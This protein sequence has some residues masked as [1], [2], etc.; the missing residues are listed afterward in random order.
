[1]YLSSHIALTCLEL[2]LRGLISSLAASSEFTYCK[3]NPFQES[4]KAILLTWWVLGNFC[5][6]KVYF[7][8]N[9]LSMQI[10]H[11]TYFQIYKQGDNSAEKLNA[12]LSREHSSPERNVLEHESP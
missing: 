6:S 5:A 1:M 12:P 2:K 9:V 7:V 4:I 10:Q 8:F 11:N 3:A